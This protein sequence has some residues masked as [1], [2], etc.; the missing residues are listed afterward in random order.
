M[1]KN[2]KYPAL[3]A[4]FGAIIIWASLPTLVKL[5]VTQVNVSFFL[6]QRFF[7]S[8]LILCWLT[9]RIIKKLKLV[10]SK[11]LTGFM[12]ALGANFYLQTYALS[13]VPAGWYVMIFAL[14]PILTLLL[15]RHNITLTTWVGIA[16]AVMGTYLFSIAQQGYLSTI[17]PLSIAALLGGMFTW[18]I[19]SVLVKKLHAIYSDTE[20]TGLSSLVALITS[21]LI[22]SISGFPVDAG[23][24]KYLPVTLIIGLIVPVAYFLYSYGMRKLPVITVNAQ[25]IEPIF[26]LFFAS[27]ILHE[28]LNRNQYL[29][30]LIVIAGTILSSEIFKA[31]LVSYEH[32]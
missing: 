2:K 26:S 21:L 24:I 28:N 22:W 30:S 18:S 11:I 4:T 17:S 29:A 10:D 8:F 31:K 27:L 19:Y 14:N 9:P 23:F 3:S 12:I 5:I 1:L 15:L 7:I 32:K 16:L 13:Q 25:Y 20:L 6:V